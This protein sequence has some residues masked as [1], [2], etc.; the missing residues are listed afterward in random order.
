MKLLS[1]ITLYRTYTQ[2]KA[3]GTRENE[4]EMFDRVNSHLSE[5]GKFNSY[6]SDL[7]ERLSRTYVS[8]MSG[9]AL[10][11]GGTNWARNPANVGGFYNCVSIPIYSPSAPPGIIFY[12]SILLSMMGCGVGCDFSDIDKLPPIYNRLDVTFVGAY[13]EVR[14]ADRQ[15]ETTLSEDMYLTVG[16]S[17]EGWAKA[18]WAL[19]LMTI[20]PCESGTLT[21]TIDLSHVRPKGELL[22]GFGGVANPEKLQPALENFVKVLNHAVGRQLTSLE[23]CLLL[24]YPAQC[25]VAG[26]IRRSAAMRQFKATDNTPTPW[27][28]DRIPSEAKTDLWVC[29]SDGNWKIDTERSALQM[30]NHTIMHFQKPTYEQILASVAKQVHTGEGAI[31]YVPE[32]LYRANVDVIDEPKNDF[33]NRFEDPN[34]SLEGYF[35]ELLPDASRY[36][37]YHRCNRYGTNPCAEIVGYYFKCNL[38][39]VHLININPFNLLQLGL[40][41][42][43]ATLE[44]AALLHQEFPDEEFKASRELDPIVLVGFTGLFDYMVMLFGA[45]WLRWFKADRDPNFKVRLSEDKIT[46]YVQI[47]DMYNIHIDFKLG[48]EFNFG[49]FALEAERAFFTY[50]RETVER[51]LRDY[52]EKHGLRCPNRCTGVKPAGTGSLLTLS[53]SGWNAPKG[54]RFIRRITTGAGD[55]VARAAIDC[56]CSVVPGTTDKDEHGNLLNDPYHPDCKTWLVEV[57][58]EVP[59]AAIADE[60]GVELKFSAVSQLRF[61]SQIQQHYTTHATSSTIDCERTDQEIESLAQE[62]H[63]MIQ[64]GLGYLSVAIMGRTGVFPRLPFE[65]ITKAQYNTM[66]AEMNARKVTDDFKAALDRYDRETNAPKASGPSGCDSDFCELK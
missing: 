39:E 22:S 18:F 27:L 21:V 56:G 16:D 2:T 31:Q 25:V 43:A 61:Y 29:D 42:K 30:G 13:G 12:Q 40:A 63:H 36:E 19:Y 37:I 17:K 8:L 48:C 65:P 46:R 34:F 24:D 62:I 50:C 41:F 10:W 1:A 33:L 51:T 11:V 35:E 44:V 3:D 45:D 58:V 23:A 52:C 59:W 14:K 54:E 49:Q 57:P 26:N 7:V 38:S 32:A 55:N 64:N 47:A 9:R 60:A 20:K 6:E 66:V 53:S 5:I 15:D 28:G 4:S